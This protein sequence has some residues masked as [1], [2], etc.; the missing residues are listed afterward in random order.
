MRLVLSMR[1]TAADGYAEARDSI[2]HDWQVRLA[3]WGA[4]PLLVPNL[5]RAPEAYLDGLEADALVL[6]GGDDPGITPERDA[7]ENLLLA[8]A[9]ARGLPVFG[10][11][12]GMQMINL[13]FGGRL[14]PIDG[15]VAK[16][17]AVKV[18]APWH[19]LY[20]ERVQV[21]SFHTIGVPTDGLAA[22]L[23]GTAFDGDGHVEGLCHPD[24]PVAGVMWHPERKG[25]PDADRQLLDRLVREGPFW[26]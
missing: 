17:H 19:D 14:A 18:A 12:R 22:G 7:T 20:G 16:S 26:R 3:D 24:L 25:A 8:R 1:I 5:I 4:T 15:H 23:I 13:H 2:S 10:V 11:C 6:T 21:N 9:V